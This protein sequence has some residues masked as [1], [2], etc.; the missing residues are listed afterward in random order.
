MQARAAPSLDVRSPH[1]WCNNKWGIHHVSITKAVQRH[2]R[3]GLTWG[4]GRMQ[5]G[6]NL[7]SDGLELQAIAHVQVVVIQVDELDIAV[8]F[9]GP[10]KGD[11]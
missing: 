1:H 11:L 7:C 5:C 3:R 6:P 2:K 10:L 4:G 8:P 9:C